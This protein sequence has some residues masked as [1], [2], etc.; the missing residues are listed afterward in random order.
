[1]N[2]LQQTSIDCMAQHI[3]T[4]YEQAYDGS[5]ASFGEPCEKCERAKEC[6]F[7]W[8]SMMLPLLGQS[9]VKISVGRQ[10]R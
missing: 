10:A 2:E 7:D 3:K 4:F 8:L 1:M 6:N 5:V 9:S